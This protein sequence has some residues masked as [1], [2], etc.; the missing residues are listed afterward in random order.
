MIM[1]WVGMVGGIVA[2]DYVIGNAS[3]APTGITSADGKLKVFAGPRSD[4]FFFNL[5]GFKATVAIVEG[6]SGLTFNDAG[7]PQLTA[8]Q[9]N[10]AAAQLGKAADG[11]TAADFFAPLN[12]LAIVISIDK[13]LLATG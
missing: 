1:C 7:C 10:A 5:D 6:L 2:M 12:G 9:S 4:P 8:G 3:V 11:G 13:A